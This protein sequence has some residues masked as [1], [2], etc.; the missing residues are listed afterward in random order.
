MDDEQDYWIPRHLDAPNLFFIWEA[1]SAFLFIVCVLLCAVL[2]MFVPGVIL[3]IFA[4]R[5]Y[6]YLKEEGGRGLLMKLM[7]WYTP[8]DTWLSKKLPSYVREY[9]GG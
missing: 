3:G 6:S 5:G 8:S 4:C 7:Y 2:N 9:I 1:D